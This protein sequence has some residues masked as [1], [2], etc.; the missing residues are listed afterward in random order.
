VGLVHRLSREGDAV[1]DAVEE[2]RLFAAAGLGA[3]RAVKAELNAN[4]LEL[5]AS[6]EVERTD[7][8]L[9]A[10]FSSEGQARIGAVRAQLSA[11]AKA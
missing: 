10:W 6:T 2:A 8:F 9:D 4:A 7:R 5:I 11:K 3:I 1:I